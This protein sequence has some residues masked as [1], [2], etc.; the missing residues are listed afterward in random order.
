VQDDIFGGGTYR[1]EGD[2]D[3]ATCASTDEPADVALNVDVLGAAYLGGS[4]LAPFV[5]AS[6]VTE[7]T[8]G[9]VA[10]LDRGMRT[11]HAPW[12]TTGF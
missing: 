2:A 1:L 12:A 10:A 8:P 11:A 3:D 5:A 7:L 4:P 9:S 6:R